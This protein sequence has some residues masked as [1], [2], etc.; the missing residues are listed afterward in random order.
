MLSIT[1]KKNLLQHLSQLLQN[2]F[3]SQTAVI[4]KLNL[5]IADTELREPYLV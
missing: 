2:L 5:D 3:T 1:V 4:M